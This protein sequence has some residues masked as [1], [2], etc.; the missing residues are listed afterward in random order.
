MRKRV[1]FPKTFALFVGLAILSGCGSSYESMTA[2][3]PADFTL[4]VSP[5][6]IFVPIGAGSSSL[7]LSVKA[8]NGFNQPV[9]IS[10]TG[11]PAGVSTTPNSPF[12]VNVGASQTVVFSA[13]NGMLPGLE[14]VSFQGALGTL[15]HSS[16]VSVSVANPVYAYVPSGYTDASGTNF[17]PNDIV[18]FAVDANTGAISAVQGAAT[19]V[20]NPPLDIAVASEPGGAFV[21]AL[22]S[23]GTT[24]GPGTLSSFK[25]DAATGSL[26]EVQ[27]INYQPG[28]EQLNLVV[29]PSGKFLYVT[30]AGTSSCTLVYLVDSATG[31]LTQ[32]SCSATG[33]LP[34]FAPPGNFAYAPTV[35]GITQE[36]MNI[37]SV[38]LTDGSLTLQQSLGTF[39]QNSR[40]LASDPLGHALYNL[41]AKLGLTE[42]CGGFFI[43][44]IDPS[45]GSLT[46]VNTSIGPLCEPIWISFTPANTFSYITNSSGN[47]NSAVA[48]YAGAV[49]PSTG[50]LANVPGSPFATSSHPTFGVVEP[51]QGKFL[52]VIGGAPALQLLA[53]TIDP[54]TGALSQVSGVGTPFTSTFPFK[55]VI[56][57]PPH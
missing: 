38:N 55:M 25:V 2:P 19:S 53:Y 48:I 26:A 23:D 40:L 16:P 21:F 32:S 3:P 27:T 9:T 5:S 6:S 12:T 13:T 56:V 31:S 29:H 42:P 34:T 20:P 28:T 30:Q 45:T 14:Q 41:A 43:Y 46:P 52:I 35:Q 33:A 47:P 1:R 22:T 39:T 57:A 24:L 36:N 8:I 18:G 15:S 44:S 10:V 4:N 11:L 51:S 37:Y 54:S 50:N 17:P 49:D 7:Q